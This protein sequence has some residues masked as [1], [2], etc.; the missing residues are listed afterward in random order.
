[1]LLYTRV[2]ISFYTQFKTKVDVHKMCMCFA[3]ISYF[4]LYIFTEVFQQSMQIYCNAYSGY[5]QL[6]GIR[7]F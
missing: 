2:K 1:M 7:K 6:S 3:R 5:L 4:S